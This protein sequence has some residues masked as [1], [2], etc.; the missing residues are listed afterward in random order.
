MNS[1]ESYLAINFPVMLSIESISKSIS[2]LVFLLGLYFS[3]DK[4]TEVSKVVFFHS[5]VNSLNL[6]FGTLLFLI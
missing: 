3:F 2:D 1:R 5:L 4:E 6:N